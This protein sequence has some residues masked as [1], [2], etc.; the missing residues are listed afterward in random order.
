MKVGDKEFNPFPQA[1]VQVS[2]ETKDTVAPF[3]YFE[4]ERS[5]NTCTTHIFPNASNHLH[6]L[7]LHSQ[8]GTKAWKAEDRA[9]AN[10]T[11]NKSLY[12]TSVRS[13]I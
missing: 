11:V 8:L 10:S 13:S 5:A 4:N 2:D 9:S 3:T 6:S 1:V 12:M 7:A